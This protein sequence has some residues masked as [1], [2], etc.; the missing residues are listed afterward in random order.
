MGLQKK[1]WL[2]LSAITILCTSL[3]GAAWLYT[4]LSIL[5]KEMERHLLAEAQMLEPSAGIA[6]QFNDHVRAAKIISQME[7]SNRHQT[8][9]LLRPDYS[10]FAGGYASELMFHPGNRV[11]RSFQLGPNSMHFSRPIR[12]N[13]DIIGHVLILSNLSAL[14][15]RKQSAWMAIAGTTV[16]SIFLAMLLSLVLH[17]KVAVP[18]IRLSERMQA[19]LSLDSMQKWSNDESTIRGPVFQRV[20]VESNDEV[21]RLARSFNSML[22]HLEDSFDTVYRQNKRILLS[23]YRFRLIIESAP[24]P[25]VISSRKD[26]SILFYNPESLRLLNLSRESIESNLTIYDYINEEDDVK[27]QQALEQDASVSGMEIRIQK[28]DGA[29]LWVSASIREIEYDGEPAYLSMLG[30]LTEHKEAERK[31]LEFNENLEKTVQ[32]RTDELLQAKELAEQANQ[33]KGLFLANMSHEIR[34]PMNAVIG[35]T[36]LLL[37]SELTPTQLDSQRKILSAA[38]KLLRIIDD[39]LD[40]SK[41]EAG[42]LELTSEIFDLSKVLHTSLAIVTPQANEKELD[43]II[44]YPPDLPIHLVGDSGRLEQVLINL[45][46]NAVKF[47]KQGSIRLDIALTAQRHQQATFHFLISDTGIGISKVQQEKLF[48]SFSQADASTS[49]EHGGTGLGLAICK[50]I[51]EMMDGTIKV[52]SEEGKGSTFDFSVR[53][54][55]QNS[56]GG[57]DIP[58][59]THTAIQG[60]PVLIVD[61]RDDSRTVISEYATMLGMKVE[62][63]NSAEQAY[64]KLCDAS[65]PFALIF[66]DWKM[67]GVN[68]FDASRM[69]KETLDLPLIPAIIM[70]TGYNFSDAAHELN[71]EEVDAWLSKPFTQSSFFDVLS[72]ALKLS[73]LIDKTPEQGMQQAIDAS[74]Q[75]A[76]SHLLLVEDNEINQEIICALLKKVKVQ[77]DIANDGQQ[78]L[79]LLRTNSY[80]AVLMDVQMP[81]MDG[82]TATEIV[83]SQS[84]YASLPII[85]MT[86]NAMACDVDQCLQA[87]MNAY[88]TKP[89]EPKD[90]YQE[91]CRW[92]PAHVDADGLLRSS[93]GEKEAVIALP[94]KNISSSHQHG[95]PELLK[96]SSDPQLLAVNKQYIDTQ[97]GLRRVSNDTGLY[98][99]ILEKFYKGQKGFVAHIRELLRLGDQD[100]ARLQAHTLKGVSGNIGAITLS[101]IAAELEQAI[102]NKMDTL[103]HQE[104]LLTE[105]DVHM[106]ALFVELHP[107]LSSTE[108]DQDFTLDVERVFSLLQRMKILLLDDDS[109][110]VDVFEELLLLLPSK[111]TGDTLAKLRASMD[112]YRFQDAVKYL[113]TIS[114]YCLQLSMKSKESEQ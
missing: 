51:I 110:A 1:L 52:N 72:V 29:Q 48:E 66:M 25:I 36:H 6:L 105:I 75:L 40:F 60:L 2:V 7:A 61:D 18:L 14:N 12:L 106:N 49:R 100:T 3:M 101:K 93:S 37:V 27:I 30:D 88:L 64:K 31:L 46:N 39:I 95:A 68:G 70:M 69:I 91:L 97:L 79:N 43:I 76:G 56:V 94:H 103:S 8:I 9:Q 82:I 42:K 19:M 53:F 65:A 111:G 32:E 98:R 109:A 81:I 89:V 92:L 44:D 99:K 80:G 63:A 112:Y 38:E 71:V 114:T 84:K 34:T 45:L 26:K 10:V 5:E 73:V 47:T 23:E 4:N 113:D 90:L 21:G 59:L 74:S 102:I 33:A 24:V 17:K 83:R 41:I 54:L 77:V 96:C 78:A 57:S 85:A 107:L 11:K 20:P 55:L 104:D 108:I 15:Q 58:M 22:T 86:A 35:L 67:P 28:P 50:Q 16:I 13:G 87:G 62:T